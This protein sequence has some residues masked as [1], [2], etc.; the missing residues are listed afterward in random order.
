MGY[1]N[2]EVA[3]RF[4]TG[5]GERCKGSNMF[6]EGN[7]IYSYGHHFPM[8]IKWNGYLLYND[9]RYSVSTAKH[10]GYV[11]GACSH[12]DIVHCAT[13]EHWDYWGKKESQAFIDLNFKRWK[14]EIDGL[15]KKMATARKPEKWLARII[16]VVERVGRFCEVFGQKLPEW[17]LN[18]DDP[19]NLERVKEVVR[20]ETKEKNER[21]RKRQDEQIQRFHEFKT[22][23]VNLPYQIVRYRE[24]KNRFE[25]SKGVEIP[26]EKGLEFYRRLRDGEL[27]VGDMV[28]FY[29]VRSVSKDTVA[30]GCHTFKRKYLLDYGKKMFN[31]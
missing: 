8:A 10:Q 22:N 18:Y 4:A 5:I 7:I 17:S 13:L 25:T 11:L 24:E 21:E 14:G 28:C 16:D 31:E 9:E 26:Y 29:R 19:K 3:H 30:V 12:M 23:W 1:S 2:S 20:Q 15:V 6:F 27:K